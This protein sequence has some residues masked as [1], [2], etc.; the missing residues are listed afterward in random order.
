MLHCR[1]CHCDWLSLRGLSTFPTIP[2]PFPFFSQSQLG[3]ILLRIF[4][5]P[6]LLSGLSPDQDWPHFLHFHIL[7]ILLDPAGTARNDEAKAGHQND[8]NQKVIQEF[9]LTQRVRPNGFQTSL[10]ERNK[11]RKSIKIA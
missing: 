4:H 10:E 7:I 8:R 5:V 2:L 6:F 9:N 1:G 3:P 11:S